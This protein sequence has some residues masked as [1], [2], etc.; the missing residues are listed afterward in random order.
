MTCGDWPCLIADFRNEGKRDNTAEVDTALDNTVEDNTAEDN[1]ADYGGR[2]TVWRRS[3]AAINSD[4]G[5]SL[6]VLFPV[7]SF[8]ETSV[9]EKMIFSRD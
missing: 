6:C 5:K 1:M 2:G 7:F 3:M 8:S 9:L 4:Q